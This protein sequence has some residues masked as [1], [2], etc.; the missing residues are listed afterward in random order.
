MKTKKSKKRFKKKQQKG[1]NKPGRCRDLR[2]GATY[3]VSSRAN[4]GE[5]IFEDE[6]DKD[7][8]MEVLERARKKYNFHI[9]EMCIM[10]THIHFIIKPAPGSSLSRIMQFIL[11]VSARIW[12]KRR[13]TTGHVWR[14]RF[15]SR[16][17]EG[18]EDLK[19][20][21]LYIQNNPIEAGILHSI[22]ELEDWKYCGAWCVKHNR[23]KIFEV[24][25]S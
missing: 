24:P 20:V 21:T 7:D 19:N 9:V 17:I 12:N 18:L 4:R 10:T 3:H 23:T 15:F 16:V 22:E 6:K 8:F 11:S 14:A 5:K 2:E 1:S 13:E 25:Q